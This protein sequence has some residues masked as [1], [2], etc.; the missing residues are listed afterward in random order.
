MN[1]DIQFRSIQECRIADA[2]WHVQTQAEVQNILNAFGETAIFVK[3]M[4]TA[5]YI[6]EL[7]KES[8]LEEAQEVLSKF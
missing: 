1:L 8:S 6:D 2:L 4:M 3:E 7:I 5:A